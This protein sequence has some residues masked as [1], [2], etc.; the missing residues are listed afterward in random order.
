[1]KMTC[2]LAVFLC[3]IVCS[4]QA[5]DL[6]RKMAEALA[7]S[8]VEL[9]DKN[10][11]K[12]KDL[13]IKALAHDDT[14]PIALYELGKMFDAE[15]NSSAASDFISRAL[16]ELTNSGK[17]EYESKIK[18][19]KFKM[20]KLNP[21]S[22]ELTVM[23]EAYA[24]ELGEV[25]KK[26]PDSLTV[27]EIAKRIKSLNLAS[28]VQAS[29]LP[30]LPK[31]SSSF[32]SKIKKEKQNLKSSLPIDVERE[33]KIAGW[34]SIDGTWKKKA[35]NTYEVTDGHLESAGPNG[36][37]HLYFEKSD[38]GILKVLARNSYGRPPRTF[39]GIIYG[40]GFGMEL[41]NMTCH[42][43]TPQAQIPASREYWPCQ[44]SET[45]L[46][47]IPLHEV[48]VKMNGS[49]FEII[50]DS[51]VA[52]KCNYKVS[53]NGAFMVTFKGTWVIKGPQFVKQ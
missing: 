49:N 14:C 8:G 10:K 4:L 32:V 40:S 28:I 51:R 11:A 13:F 3:A 42:I 15:G 16:L 44:E 24:Q 31:P 47:E 33:M 29:K 50:I 2:A 9:L 52:K 18:D 17:P 20:Q 38:Q 43:F 23:M 53:E 27:Q 34:A 37:I 19:A 46:K 22:E 5:D 36:M 35:E 39:D 41:Q 6:D 48:S 1:M 7:N 25:V 21:Q 26:S 12:A 30:E 45:Q